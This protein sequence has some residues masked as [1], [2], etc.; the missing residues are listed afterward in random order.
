MPSMPASAARCASPGDRMPLSTIG[1]A[2]VLAQERQVGPG[3]RGSPEQLGVA[4]DGAVTVVLDRAWPAR[5]EHRVDEVVL[6]AD[7]L[8]ERQVAAWSRSCGRQAQ[9][10]GVE[11]DD[12]DAEAGRL[13]PGPGSWRPGPDRLGQYSWNHRGPGAAGRG[14]LLQRS[15][16]RGAESIIGMPGSAA[17]RAT[18]SSPSGCA[19]P[20]TPTGASSIGTGTGVP[21][22]V[23]RVGRGADIGQ[24]PRHDPP[25]AQRRQVLPRRVTGRRRCRRHSRTPAGSAPGR[26]ASSSRLRSSAGPGT[27]P[28]SPFR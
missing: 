12:Q 21:R 3:Q 8:Q 10:P 4:Q 24:H 17:A 9:H 2:P 5:L 25:A 28:V 7:A 27:A 26:A 23:G 19:M 22:I 14:D 11:G 20:S 1:P 16:R 18:A 13:R 6:H 15:R